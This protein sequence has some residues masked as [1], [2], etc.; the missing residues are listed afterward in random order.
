MTKYIAGCSGGKDSVATLILA[1]ERG[2]P[3]DE[4][5]YSEVMFDP[6]TS[7]EMPEHRDFVYNQ[8]KPF[9]ESVLN[10]PFIVLR[11]NK[12][13][14][15]VFTHLMTRG[16]S[17]GRPYG[18]AFPGM[19]AI[20]RDCKIPPITKYWKENGGNAVQYVGI[21]A[22]EPKRL[23]RLRGTPRV[24]LLEK[25]GI[26]EQ[27]AAKICREHNL[28]SPV[29]E[30]SKRNGCWFCPNC[31]DREWT[32]LIFHHEALFDRLVELENSHPDRVR[33][34]LTRCETP[35]QLKARIVNNGEQCSM[36]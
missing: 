26:T 32:H 21:A 25:Y 36:F 30:F 17:V 2:E 11:S 35:E 6:N 15:D 16:A 29:Y 19:C 5:V 33:R 28:L 34:C 20:N 9:V 10:V 27:Q 13:Y 24:S 14:L 1:K 7:G 3:L 31:S 8:L 12:T 22:D 18:F 23:E 4:V